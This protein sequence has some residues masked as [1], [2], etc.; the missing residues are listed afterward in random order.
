MQVVDPGWYDLMI[1]GTTTGTDITLPRLFTLTGGHF[2]VYL[3]ETSITG[4]P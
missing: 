2:G 1:S 3:V 4:Q